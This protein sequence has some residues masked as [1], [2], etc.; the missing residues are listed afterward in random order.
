METTTQV[1]H[2]EKLF[3][4]TNLIGSVSHVERG[5]VEVVL[6]SM[7]ASEDSEDPDSVVYNGEI[8]QFVILS[9]PELL[10]FA[11]ITDIR[12]ADQGGEGFT[13]G[14]SQA[15][16][17]ATVQ[18]LSTIR[19]EDKKVIPGAAASPKVGQ[20]AYSAA[21]ELVRFVA[22]AGQG[23]DDGE[24]VAL[25]FATLLDA[26]KSEVS[27]TPEMLFGRHCAVL[28]TTGAGKSW[29][30]AKIIEEISRFR[31]K[32]IL[33][34]ATGEFGTLARSTRHVYLGHDPNAPEGAFEVAA[35]Y[36]EL[37]E[38]DLFAIFKPRGQSQAPK[39]RAAM[40]SLKLAELEPSLG[41]DGTIIKVD[42]SKDHFESA[43]RRHLD[44]I[45]SPTA[46][47]D[48]SKLTRQIE[49]E[50]VKTNRSA[51]EPMYWG[52]LNGADQASCLPLITRIED[53]IKS[54]ALAPVFQP[55]DKPSL[56]KVL[57]YFIKKDASR[58]LRISLEHLSFQHGAR[59]IV[60]NATGRFLLNM[61]RQGAF[62]R[63]PILTIVDEAH[64][65][66]K[67]SHDDE[68]R[69]FPLDSFAIIAKEGRKYAFNICL[70]TQRPRDIPEGVL[71]QMGT[72]IVHR[73]INHHD[74]S[75]VERAS[76]EIDRSSLEMLPALA[77]GQAVLL[78][79]DF[80]VPLAVQVSSPD[81]RP[82]SRGP[83][84][85]KYWK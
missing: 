59:E 76:A 71:S 41:L 83:D 33:F 1:E 44:V 56:F 66:L 36:F 19:L 70:A 50:C 51:F 20:K 34:D 11:Q 3:D 18:L 13:N 46:D 22:E 37:N 48:I 15:H 84:Y 16:A 26:S 49:N 2:P 57:D 47:F 67:E 6:A 78:G 28:G 39:L 63:R 61:A 17:I 43:Y 24:K 73:L 9:F 54:E 82:E 45:E 75:V 32:V 62:R 38:T 10:L 30:V 31:S 81:C 72:M 64:H 53:I 65:F 29:T 69:I 7:N 58:V 25:N 85:Q 21:P 80:P 77:P 60:A 27:F 40:K 23:L 79:V 35:P 68:S 5:A 52:G 55:G 4:Q 14:G 42:K 12:M 8:G 74:R